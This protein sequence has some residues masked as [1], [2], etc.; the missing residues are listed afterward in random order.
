[1][2]I[3]NTKRLEAEFKDWDGNLANV[4]DIGLTIAD[5]NRAVVLALTSTSTEI[6]NLSTGL[7][8]YDYALGSTYS[9]PL[10]YEFYGV[11]DGSPISRR[12]FIERAWAEYE[13]K[14]ELL[15]W[16]KDYCN[17][18]FLDDDDI[19]KI[20]GGVNVFLTQAVKYI[21]KQEGKTSES[22]GDYS[23]AWS[24]DYPESMLRLLRPYRRVVFV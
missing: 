9:S 19:E 23:V 20:P 3:G 11:L 17:N 2:T 15:V 24:T 18:D 8:Y 22:L 7:Y 4:T 6:I 21:E 12:G 5:N 14:A 16:V 1:M 10:T 13:L